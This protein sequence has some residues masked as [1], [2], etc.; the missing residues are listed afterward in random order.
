[1]E[2]IQTKV[3]Q[4]IAVARTC[5]VSGVTYYHLGDLCEEMKR[6]N[7][8]SHA[9]LIRKRSGDIV[10]AKAK[11]RS[12]RSQ[13]TNFIS[14]VEVEKMC[15][16]LRTR[17]EAGVVYAFF[18]MASNTVFKCGRTEKWETRVYVGFNRPR[19][20][21]LLEKVSHCLDTETIVL[22]NLRKHGSFDKD[23]TKYSGHELLVGG[24]GS[25][26]TTNCLLRI[27]RNLTGPKRQRRQFII[28]SAQW[29][30]DKT[31]KPLKAERFEGYVTGV[32][33]GEAAFKESTHETEEDFFRNEIK[34]K[35]D[36]ASR[37][38]VILF[39]DAREIV[40]PGGVR[41]LID[42]LLR[43][44]RHSGLT[45]MVILHALKSGHWSSQAYSSVKYLTM[46]PRSQKAKIV[47]FLNKDLAL[48][49]SEARDHVFAFSQTGRSMVAR[50]HAPEMLI[51]PKLIRLL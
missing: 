17:T 18:P 22:R 48:P 30:M 12:N 31:L 34:Y 44:G 43:V 4:V 38:T 11:D 40:F 13:M 33:C 39:D 36:N 35:I 6:R 42:K 14:R 47:A 37:G 9:A 28:F 20:M 51:G 23:N 15:M 21:I 45:I 29:E 10:K 1:M 16:G 41:R 3:N 8:C 50:F 26:K 25:G 32:D 5:Q 2:N 27:L 46:F 19:Q 7:P 49:L 24:T